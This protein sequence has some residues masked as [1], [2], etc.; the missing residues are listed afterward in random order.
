MLRVVALHSRLG[1][2]RYP[3]LLARNGTTRA[4]SSAGSARVKSRAT[5]C[6]MPLG[7]AQANWNSAHALLSAQTKVALQI[8]LGQIAPRRQPI[9]GFGTAAQLESESHG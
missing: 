1:Y 2:F 6:F 8:G 3:S 4:S 5:G 9:R 7:L